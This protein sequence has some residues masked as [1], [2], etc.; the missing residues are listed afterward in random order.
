[1]LK[2]FDMPVLA[3]RSEDFICIVDRAW[4]DC[5]ESQLTSV[6]LNGG[7]TQE[8]I[9][10]RRAPRLPIGYA[11]DEAFSPTV[12]LDYGHSCR[13]ITPIASPG[14]LPRR[15]L[16]RLI[17]LESMAKFPGWASFNNIYLGGVSFHMAT[18]VAI[19]A[20]FTIIIAYRQR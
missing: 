8:V 4:L 13:L 11:V 5:L 2:V 15:C 19:R 20:M 10:D 12:A 17:T 7:S 16:H 6:A 1:L 18:V 3:D 9:Y 14:S